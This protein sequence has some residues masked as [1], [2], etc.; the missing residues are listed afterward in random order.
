MMLRR[1]EQS[2]E[3]AMEEQREHEAHQNA[4]A[5]MLQGP[6]DGQQEHLEQL[7]DTGVNKNTVYMLSNLLSQDFV[8][9][10]Y[11]A[12]EVTEVK[13]LSRILLL[14]LE[15]M[16]PPQGGFWVGERRAR[17]TGDPRENLQPLSDRDRHEIEQ[18]LMAIFARTTRGE[19][20][21]QQEQLGKQI[22]V[23][24]HRQTND[25]QE[26]GWRMFG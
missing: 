21:E 3:E 18:A 7:L 23:S 2:R 20:M 5:A 16:H 10:N 1:G 25:Q 22:T 13:W 12:A 11:N 4:Q 9:A 6:I 17:V 19:D 15:A 8:L 14:E 24:E 26:S